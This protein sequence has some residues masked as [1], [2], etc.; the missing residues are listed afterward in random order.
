MFQGKSILQELCSLHLDWD[1]PI[2]EDT[3]MRGEKR[4]MELMKLQTIRIPRCY[5]PKDFGQ[6]VRAELQHFSDRSVWG[7]G[8]CSYL[9]PIDD[10]NKVHC[11]FVM[12][13]S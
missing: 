8:Q 6:V 13:K 1:D 12:G 3:K 9:R 4:R 11:A 2:A 10:T 5:K 7:Y